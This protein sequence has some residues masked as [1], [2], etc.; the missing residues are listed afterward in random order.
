MYIFG[1]NQYTLDTSMCFACR[2]YNKTK[3][4]EGFKE[5]IR[6]GIALTFVYMCLYVAKRNKIHFRIVQKNRERERERER[7]GC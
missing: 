7:M 3:R 2:V 4:F 1:Q 6:P 5:K